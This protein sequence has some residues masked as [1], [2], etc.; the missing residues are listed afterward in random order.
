MNTRDIIK[1]KNTIKPVIRDAV[2]KKKKL[3]V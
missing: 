3:L 2:M 1:L